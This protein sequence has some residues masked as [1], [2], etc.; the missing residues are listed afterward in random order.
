MTEKRESK[1]DIENQG[2][3]VNDRRRFDAEGQPRRE[4]GSR[5]IPP[6]AGEPGPSRSGEAKGGGDEWGHTAGEEAQ[7]L[8]ADFSTLLLSLASSAQMGLGLVPHPATGRPEKNLLQAKHA[9]DLLGTLQE[10]TQGNLSREEQQLIE[11][12]LYDLRIQFVEAKK[13]NEHGK[14]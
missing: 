11:A 13:G 6:G 5:E 9:I 7:E 2:F 1:E 3:K 8:P 10:K 12:L 4:E 14:K